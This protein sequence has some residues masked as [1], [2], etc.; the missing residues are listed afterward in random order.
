GIHML[1]PEVFDL[2]AGWPAKFSIIDFYLAT[3]ASHRI[4]ATVP[5][6]LRL[7]DMGTPEAVK[8]FKGL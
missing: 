2:M 1:S 7:Q 8:S 4:L 5:D 6:S 3:C